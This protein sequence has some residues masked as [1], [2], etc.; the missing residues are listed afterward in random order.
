M[1]LVRAGLG[2]EDAARPPTAGRTTEVLVTRS[3][4]ERVKPQHRRFYVIR[5]GDTLDA[6]A[7]RMR[8]SVER[9][10]ELNPGVEP[11]SLRIGQKIRTA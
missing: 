11:T 5:A 7:R 1:L 2:N 4:A 8:V 10:L 9:L 3:P 6:V